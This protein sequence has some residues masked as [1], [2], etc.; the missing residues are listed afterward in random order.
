MRAIII[1]P[2][3]EST[4]NLFKKMF[5]LD[6]TPGTPHLVQRLGNHRWEISGVI[7]FLGT[8]TGVVVIRLPRLLADKLL[9]RTGMV[10]ETERQREIM[11]NE[12][13]G[14]FTNIIAGNALGPL[15]QKGI[16]LDISPPL[17]VQG[18]NHR[19]HWPSSAPIIGMPFTTDL[20]PFTV[21]VSMKNLD[22][23]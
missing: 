6:P 4:M 19:I 2:F 8:H 13:V 14:E 21:D 20:G 23:I 9:E 5:R 10:F 7:S 22:I 1:N 17:V 16:D 3:L 12:M 11:I 18:K 15:Y